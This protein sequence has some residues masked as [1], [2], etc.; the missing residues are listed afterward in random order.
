MRQ[1]PYWSLNF[2]VH[3]HWS[4]IPLRFS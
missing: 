3:D 1:A 2:K 4:E